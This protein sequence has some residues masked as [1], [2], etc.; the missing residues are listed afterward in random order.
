MGQMVKVLG[1]IPARYNSSRFHAKALVDI[2]GKSMVQRVYEQASKAQSLD[3]VVVATDHQLIYDHVKSFGGDV[4][5]TDEQHQSGTDRCFEAYQQ[6]NEQFDYVM[7][8]QGDEPFIQPQQIDILA[9]ILTQQ[10]DVEL[11]TLIKK[12]THIDHVF[13][14]N[15]VKVLFD[16]HHKAIYFS[17]QAIPFQRGVSQESWLEHH[18]YFKHLGIYAYRTDV[19]AKI[20]QLQPSSY[21]KMEALEQ[22][23]WL[24]NGFAIYVQETEYESYGVDTPEDLEEILKLGLGN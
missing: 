5:M 14:V 3:K 8:I 6:L 12:I 7:N 4:V 19:L 17:R 20:T 23:R 10:D 11:A 2:N 15:K 9:A 18:D 13:D 22:L 16:H 21:E 1:I 24:Q